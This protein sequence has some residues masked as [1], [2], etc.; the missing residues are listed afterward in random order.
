VS[1]DPPS[2][3]LL[4]LSLPEMRRD[5]VVGSLCST[6]G[7]EWRASLANTST[8]FACNCRPA[9][10]CSASP[11]TGRGVTCE[12]I[13][14]NGN[15]WLPAVV[16]SGLCTFP[17]QY[18]SVGLGL[19]LGLVLPF[20]LFVGL[21][22]RYLVLRRRQPAKE[23]AERAARRRRKLAQAAALPLAACADVG[24]AG[25]AENSL[26]AS[27]VSS[28]PNVPIPPR[29]VLSTA[30]SAASESQATRVPVSEQNQRI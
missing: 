15:V 20:I 10:A 14:V 1:A 27:A 24:N 2:V 9:Q 6:S 23:R 22:A 4:Q 21:S 25:G 11:T 19:G 28:L 26:T 16:E 5:N 13:P 30:R 12:V 3:R 18:L 7:T 29:E 8:D 17:S